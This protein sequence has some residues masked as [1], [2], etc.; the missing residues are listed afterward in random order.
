MPKEQSGQTYLNVSMSETVNTSQ[1]E[2][3]NVLFLAQIFNIFPA[4]ALELL[5]NK[6]E[7]FSREQI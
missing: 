1:M 4:A 6:P 7:G 3:K 5:L 2:D